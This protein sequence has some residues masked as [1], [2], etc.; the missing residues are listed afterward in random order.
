M[1][2]LIL[3]LVVWVCCPFLVFASEVI[4][5]RYS[6]FQS[7]ETIP[8]S[9]FIEV[10][11]DPEGNLPFDSVVTPSFSDRFIPLAKAAI[12][13]N[14]AFHWIRFTIINESAL[15]QECKLSV[16]FADY[17]QFYHPHFKD[18][19]GSLYDMQFSGDRV[20]LKNRAVKAGPLVFFSVILPAGSRQTFYARIESKHSI[21][22]Q[23]LKRTFYS[24]NVYPQA[25]FDNKYGKSYIV[26]Q[27]L[28][29]GA[30]IVM[31][32]YNFFIYITLKDL[33]YLFYVCY[34]LMLVIFLSANTGLLLELVLPDYPEID[35]YLR[36]QS[37][38]VLLFFYVLFSKFY[39][40]PSQYARR[41][42]IFVNGLLIFLP[43][44]LLAMMAGYWVLGRNLCIVSV[45]L[46]F[47]VLIGISIES[48]SRGYTPAKYFL[49]AN[50]LLILGGLAYA[51]DNF[52]ASAQHLFAQY[53]LQIGVISEII[54]FSFGLTYRINLIQLAL[55]DKILENERLE[56]ERERDLK[57]LIE[58]KNRE[59][60]IKVTERTAE[61]VHQKEEI[62]AQNELLFLN[63][64]H[65]EE[66]QQ[67]I[68]KQNQALSSANTRLEKAVLD[69]T[70]EL[71]ATNQR[72]IKSNL[73]LDRFI[74]RT[75]HDIKGPLARLIGLSHVALLDVADKT[76]LVYLQK[77]HFEAKHLN[78]ILSRLSTIYEINHWQMSVSTIE[79][80]ELVKQVF[81][82]IKSVEGYHRMKLSVDVRQ[83]LNFC[84][85]EKLVSFILQNL[86]ENAV[87]FQQKSNETT[88]QVQV[89]V[90]QEKSN[91]IIRVADN[92]IGILPE[93]APVIFDMFSKAAHTHKTAG[94]GL[95]MARLCAQ[96]L[97]GSIHLVE[98][99]PGFTEFIVSLPYVLPQDIPNKPA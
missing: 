25:V 27:S 40:K 10:A 59:L 68:K 51:L 80:G 70:K 75:S 79:F 49:I 42:T 92:G 94:M 13:D 90:K 26:Y 6:D 78:Y 67:L 99:K 91:L 69:R 46:S 4:T 8:L 55:K 1:S 12:T 15:M 45:I 66:A 9:S 86:A 72:L 47:V 84:S 64:T 33:A 35:L 56:K 83:N 30:V 82:K 65:L 74:Y 5:L 54:F 20:P 81:E 17:I 41:W 32:M 71:R 11:T 28:F 73:E 37:T 3:T 38:P 61:V 52:I 34:T 14:I 60:E 22:R 88:H 57:Q 36:F 19:T 48:L 98:S 97:G 50:A 77:L 2:K 39:L 62:I 29:F 76:S 16:P 58:E 44:I 43:L 87:F 85:D 95:Y 23:F 21:A 18:T 7:A 24:I 53:S 93:E 63:N 96:K 31:M 89:E